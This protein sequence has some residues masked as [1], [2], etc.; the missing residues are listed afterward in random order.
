[1][2]PSTFTRRTLLGAAVCLA[3]AGGTA[4]GQE[5]ARTDRHVILISI[6][7][8]AAFYLDDPRAPIPNIRR[9]AAEGVR[10]D[11]MTVSTPS[12]TW[13]NHTTLVTGVPPGR[14]GV[15]ANGRIEPQ[16][17]GSYRIE[18]RRSRAELCRVETVYDAAHAAGLKTAEINWP[19]TRDAPTLHW[20]FPD[21]PSPIRYST[22]ALTQALVEQ[23][24]LKEPTDAAFT[25]IGSVARDEV[26]TRAATHLIRKERPNLLLLHLLYSD[27]VQHAH[28]PNT[29]EAYAAL[30]LADRYV[31]DILQATRDAGIAGRTSVIVTADHGFVRTTK[32]IAPSVRFREAGLIRPATGTAAEFDAYTVS[33]GG[34]AL[35]YAK[36][37]RTEPEFAARVRA[38][39]D[40]IEGIERVIE[41]RDYAPLG[42]PLPG[43]D[44][45]AP[46]FVLSAK[47]GYAFSGAVSGEL[48][49]ERPRAGGTHGYVQTNPRVDGLFVAAGRGIRKGTRLERIQNLDVAP[50][51]ARLLGVE[52][53]GAEGKPLAAALQ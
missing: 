14:H 2:N 34:L 27:G 17:D 24:L 41:P 48:I 44:P 10:A 43:S 16:P 18:P 19:V 36:R 45:Q 46:D 51:I 20:R 28:G 23:K 3:L 39:L 29:D 12:V 25:A 32:S 53:K 26:W 1:M 15:L 42:L 8:F 5:R 52:L 6:D 38:A 30:A 31:G 35:V 13:P 4:L 7:G 50:T 11:R 49:A 47:D 21:H 22:P 40:N 37:A 33:E 9:L